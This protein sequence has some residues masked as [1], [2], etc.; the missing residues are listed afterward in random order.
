MI[1]EKIVENL[2]TLLEATGK[3]HHQAFIETDGADPEWPLW[4]ANHLKD[5]LTRILEADLTQ[6]EIVYLLL[7]SEAQR[8]THAPGAKWPRFYARLWAERY[9]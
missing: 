7:H 8:V 2:A 5:A 3:S 4:Y 6:A 9:A 1:Q